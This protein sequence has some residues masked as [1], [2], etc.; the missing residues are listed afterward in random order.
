MDPKNSTQYL[1]GH[2]TRHMTAFGYI[3]FWLGMIVW[4]VGDLMFLAIVFRRSLVWFFGC[5]FV[6]F[7]D[8]VYFLLYPKET[9]KPM[10]ITTV[11]CLAAG[12]GY[13]LGGFSFLQ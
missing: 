5:L 8:L 4:L 12:V 7:F 6:P 11:G 9:W 13:W 2:R 10:L 3:I 1:L